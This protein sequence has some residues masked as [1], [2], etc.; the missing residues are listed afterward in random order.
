MVH[1]LPTGARD[2]LPLDVAQKQWIKRRLQQRFERWGYHRII[3]PTLEK[4]ET[5]TAGG[6]VNPSAVIQLHDAENEVLGLRPELTASV[7]RAAVARMDGVSL[8]Q[9]LYYSANVFRRLG[10]DS[11]YHQHEFYQAGVE[12]VGSGGV[13]ADAEMLLLLTDCLHSLGLTDWHII[14]GEAALTRSL[15]QTFPVSH[16]KAILSAFATVDRVALETMPLA[17]DLRQ[18]ALI[19]FDLR[20]QQPEDVIQQLAQLNLSESQRQLVN[21]LKGLFDLLNDAW[22]DRQIRSASPIKPH[23]VLDLSLIQTFDYYSGIVFDVVSVNG[24]GHQ[25]L[26]QGG[27]YDHLLGVYHPEGTSYPGVGFVLNVDELHQSLLST[28]RLPDQA[29]TSNWL[30]V[31][32]TP[33]AHGAAFA[34]AQ[35]IRESASLVRVEVDLSDRIS[36]DDARQYA[37]QR[38][39]EQL[40][41][42]DEAGNPTIERLI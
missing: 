2:L 25:R 24:S 19:L 13:V 6:A 41:W 37:R 32:K 5:L 15:L 4:L 9:R 18:H 30:V 42:I 34:Y 31:P 26:G 22:Q 28:G 27:R 38:R 10:Q 7:A 29:P 36:L 12:M 39:I 8:P 3:T 17:D 40:A 1:Q 11:S 21:R 20:G 16:Q 14:I 35:R 23:I 33:A